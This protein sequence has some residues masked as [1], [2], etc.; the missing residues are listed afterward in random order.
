[1]QLAEGTALADVTAPDDL[2]DSAPAAG[3]AAG[4]FTT[5]GGVDV[6]SV[7][8]TPLPITQENLNVPIDAGWITAEEVC[9]GVTAGSV[10]V[11]E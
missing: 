5:P 6:Y 10:S 8:L 7:I 1:M 4:V 2:G 11:C 9:Q 3:T